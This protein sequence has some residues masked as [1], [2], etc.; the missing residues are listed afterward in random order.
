[1]SHAIWVAICSASLVFQTL[2]LIH[3]AVNIY[4]IPFVFFATLC[5]YNFH[6]LLGYFSSSRKI[7]FHSLSNRYTALLILTAGG[8]GV[9]LFFSAAH[10]PLQN[11]VI[12]FLLTFLYSLP[13]VPFKQLAFARKA[14]FVKTLLLA[15]TWM[16]VTAYLPL[17]QNNIAFTSAGLLIMAKRFLFM[18]MLCIIFDN[19]DVAV[20]KIHGLSSLATDLSPK[21]MQWLI[22]VIFLM[23]FTINF[24]LGNHGITIRQVL[25]LQI[26]AV[27]NVIIYFLSTKKQGYIFYYFAVDG[28]MV[29][30]TLLTTIASI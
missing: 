24:L 8:I 9:L 4:L 10:I 1:L 25:A 16:F 23:L 22:A 6:Y 3:L 12:A 28:M 13:L 30:M 2:Q 21:A 7:S 29:L 17:S 15:F 18:L 5:S 19:R 20:D 14:G 11:V 27:I 26:A